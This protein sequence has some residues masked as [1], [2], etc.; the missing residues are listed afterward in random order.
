MRDLGALAEAVDA[1]YEALHRQLGILAECKKKRAEEDQRMTELVA[2]TLARRN[3]LIAAGAT[4]EEL[5]KLV[6][7]WQAKWAK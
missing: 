2:T 7:D 4:A 5:E 1:Y 3:E 6:S